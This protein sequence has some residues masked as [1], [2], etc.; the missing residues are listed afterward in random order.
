MPAWASHTLTEYLSRVGFD[1]H[2]QDRHIL[3]LVLDL[4]NFK[5]INDSLGHSAGDQLLIVVAER[6]RAC[7]AKTDTVARLG[8]DEFTIL[9]EDLPDPSA[10][11]GVAERIAE[12]LSRPVRLGDRLVNV[13]ASI[14]VVIPD[15]TQRTPGELLQAADLALYAAKDAGKA[16]WA[17]FDPSMA[18]SAVDRLELEADLRQA[19]ERQELEL[20]YQPLIQLEDG[21]VTEL[22]ALVRWRHPRRGLVGPAEF[23]TIAEDTGLIVPLGE[24][25]LETACRQMRAWQTQQPPAA[26][27]L[28]VSV[29]LSARQLQSPCLVEH[30]RTTLASTG[31][32]P[33]TLKL[34]IT[35]SVAVADT[36]ANRETL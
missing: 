6:L 9:L 30:V 29:N 35:E 17:M 12:A 8:G 27:P 13:T 11:L 1:T 25:V 15:A 34:E 4:D 22:E 28:V 32:D 16:R 36:H 19:L 33:S 21:R 24:W 3:R 7:V 18:A 2:S 26:Q 20:H 31:L 14:G 10:A 5:V 23:I